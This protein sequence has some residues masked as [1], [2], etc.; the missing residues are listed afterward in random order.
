MLSLAGLFVPIV[1]EMKE[2]RYE[3]E[4]AHVVDDSQF[5]ATFG[6]ETTPLPDAV[7]ATVAWFRQQHA[8]AMKQAA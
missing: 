5:R 7:R 1:R 8:E 2:M 6:A 3:F 4:A